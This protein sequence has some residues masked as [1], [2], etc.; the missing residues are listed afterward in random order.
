MTIAGF[1]ANPDVIVVGAGT[2][3]RACAQALI[4]AGKSVLVLEAA[5]H[6]GGRC[7][8]DTA[9]L[10]MPFDIGGSWLHAA[11]INPL[12]PLAAKV[13]IALD[14]TPADWAFVVD[15]G[16]RLRAGELHGYSRAHQQMWDHLNSAGAGAGDVAVAS[17]LPDQ[18]HIA[19][20][21]HW[22]AQM[23]GGDADV[24]SVQDVVRYAEVGGDWLVHGGLGA[25]VARLFADVPVRCDCPVTAIEIAGDR[26]RAV[27]PHGTAEAP[28]LVVT[29]STGVLRGG[30]IHFTPALPATHQAA[31][32][33]LPMGLLNK[34]GLAFAPGWQQAH[35]GQI[36]DYRASDDAFCTIQFGMCG[37][38]LAM[39]FLAGR[40]ADRIEA[41]GPGAATDFCREALRAIFGSDVTRH[42]AR[43]HETAWRGNP[44]ARGSYSHALPGGAD[45]RATLARPV[46]GRLFFAGE[47]TIPDAYATVH[48][49]YLSG[50]AAARQVV[51]PGRGRTARA[52]L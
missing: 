28:H 19:M 40:F 21:R 20:T 10:G 26:V 47:A 12:V 51:A 44:L 37:T 30:G 49:A 27:T 16:R 35:S 42:I 18:P 46:Q 17:L 24:V 50:R 3:G 14:K 11:A 7:H 6:P 41:E 9:A 45:A 23:H 39:G 43:T 29:V 48:G 1:P 36:A 15:R 22:V 38:G 34:I 52:G 33:Q 13:G 4:D 31:L 2:A 5:A 8:T 32:E 25:L